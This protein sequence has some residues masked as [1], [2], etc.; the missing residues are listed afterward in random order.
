MKLR[1]QGC[2]LILGHYRE[3]KRREANRIK[4]GVRDMEISNPLQENF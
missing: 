1:N 3:V 2:Q 4:G